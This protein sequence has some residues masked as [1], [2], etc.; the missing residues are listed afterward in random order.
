MMLNCIIIDDEPLAR[1][2]LREYIGD[3]SFLNLTAEFD[4]ALKA[5]SLLQTTNLPLLFLDI[6]MPK[7]SGMDFLKSLTQPPPVIFT[8]AYPQYALD[9]FEV[10]ALDYLVK[11]ISFE[12]FL[13]AALKAKAHYDLRQPLA[14]EATEKTSDHF[15]IK[16]DA[17]LTKIYV[18]DIL[19]VEALQNY[20]AIYT[21]TKKHISYLTLSAIEAYLPPEKF[22]KI[23][24]SYVIALEKVDSIEGSD[25]R[26]QHHLIPISRHLKDAVLERL[27]SNRILK[28]P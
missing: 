7:L 5:A 27:T 19:F 23:H 26:L 3:V 1:K 16:E 12:R 20:V 17:R 10:A 4:T 22:L 8:T 28:R 11:P 15:F 9:G 24:K 13:K 2:G 21:N 14:V 6:Q 25:V 18:A